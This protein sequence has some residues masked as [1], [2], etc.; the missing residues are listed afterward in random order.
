MQ[1]SWTRAFKPK[2]DTEECFST[3]LKSTC[4]NSG[5]L[6]EN[7]FYPKKSLTSLFHQAIQLNLLSGMQ[8]IVVKHTNF[9]TPAISIILMA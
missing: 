9:T 3:K 1:Q 5:L 6:K 8:P 4:K 7:K 2:K